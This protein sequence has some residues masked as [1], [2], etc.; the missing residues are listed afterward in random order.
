[1]L[2]SLKMHP[3]NADHVWCQTWTQTQCEATT[4]MWEGTRKDIEWEIEIPGY[5]QICVQIARRLYEAVEES[6]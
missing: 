6:F 5:T 2:T 1:M 3:Q 4:Q